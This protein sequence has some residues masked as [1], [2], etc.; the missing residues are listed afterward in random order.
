MNI[1][2]VSQ[3]YT[4][5]IGGTEKVV[6]RLSE[7]LVHQFNDDVTVYTTNC[8]SAEAFY[9]PSLPRMQVG[10]ETI[11]GVR[12]RRFGVSSYVSRFLRFPQWIAYNLSFPGNQYLRILS[13][14]PVI[15]ELGRAIRKHSFD[16]MMATSFPLLH[17]FTSA[18]AAER[19]RRP[20]AIQGNLHPQDT[21]SFGKPAIY[22]TINQAP[23]YIANTEYE[24]Q[25]VISQ[26]ATP[27]RVTTIGVGVDLDEFGRISSEEAKSRLGLVGKPVVGFVGQIAATKGVD[28]LVRAMA[29]VW[30]E[31]PEVYL[32]IAG[33]RTLFSN[34]IEDL[35]SRIPIGGLENV[36][37]KYNFSEAD[38]PYLFSAIDVFVYPSGYE[39][40]GIAFLEAWSSKNP[41]IGC[42]RGAITSVIEAGKDGLLVEYQNDHLL[43]EAIKL[44][45]RNPD[46][47]KEMGE[48]GYEKVS[49]RFT[50]PEI[51]R[52]Y[53]QVYLELSKDI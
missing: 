10:W 28:T 51:A 38:K 21:W 4:P 25:Y 20:Y 12:I 46:W 19:V 44:L 15:P 26:G 33:S 50:W 5:A 16:V 45:L 9:T 29:H 34:Q 13:G 41:V 8:Y 32:L 2:H 22:K 31:Y 42:R 24:A 18:R 23:C 6:Q 48:S 14:G 47:A 1:L 17:T 36:L 39:S 43:A 7:E 49:R 27:S 40:F 35:I 11:N 30:E 37:L 53:R 3:G 52:R